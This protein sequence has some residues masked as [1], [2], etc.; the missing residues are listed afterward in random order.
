[1]EYQLPCE[2][3]QMITV[4]EGSAGA[5]IPCGCG[6]SVKVPSLSDLRLLAPT[7]NELDM[8]VAEFHRTLVQLTPRAFVTPTIV[9]LNLLVFGLMAAN[10]VNVVS[11][12]ID[13]LLE[14]GGEFRA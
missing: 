3:G 10:G 12:T 1:M 9:G 14:W 11:P 6:R 13:S 2:C 5:T 8:S 4:S 7:R